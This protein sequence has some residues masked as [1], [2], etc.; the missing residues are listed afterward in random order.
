MA[1]N[2]L[3]LKLLAYVPNLEDGVRD[4][5]AKREGHFAYFRQGYVD[6]NMGR[7]IEHTAAIIDATEGYA[8]ADV[9]GEIKSTSRSYQ[10]A[11]EAIN[12]AQPKFIPDLD[13]D[14]DDEPAEPVTASGRKS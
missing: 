4:Y 9:R 6:I 12:K 8:I 7:N 13:I 11:A 1:D 2:L 3:E 5:C 14:L 10:K